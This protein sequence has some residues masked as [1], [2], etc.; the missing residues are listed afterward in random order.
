MRR[1]YEQLRLYH[2]YIKQIKQADVIK[3]QLH[4]KEWRG[5][6]TCVKDPRYLLKVLDLELPQRNEAFPEKDNNKTPF[7]DANME[8]LTHHISWLREVLWDNQI[9]PFN[10]KYEE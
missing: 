4:D 2:G 1:S 3:I 10:E 9:V 7:H 6:L 5:R 8:D